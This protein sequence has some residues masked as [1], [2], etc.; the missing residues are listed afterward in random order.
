MVSNPPYVTVKDKSKMA[1][2][3]LDYEPHQALFVPEDDPLIFYRKIVDLADGHLNK[4]GKI[5]FEINESFGAEI[6]SLLMDRGF[7]SV[8]LKKDLNGRIRMAKAIKN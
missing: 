8:Q 2:N 3:V 7:S 1:R 5:F 6:R 4:G